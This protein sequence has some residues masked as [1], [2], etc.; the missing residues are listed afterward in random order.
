MYSTQSAYDALYALMQKNEQKSTFSVGISFDN[1]Y[2]KK[3]L[4]QQVINT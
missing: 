1:M 2:S 3:Y 4:Q